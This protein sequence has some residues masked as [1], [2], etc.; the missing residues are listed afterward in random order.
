MKRG[1]LAATSGCNAETIRYYEKIGLIPEPRRAANGYREYD[2]LHQERLHFVQRGRE[3]GFTIDD[4]KSLLSLVDRN[5]VSCNEVEKMA[6]Q[7]L[8]S[9]QNKIEQLKRMEVIL[10]E[11]INSCSGEDVP[12]CPLI[13]SLFN[14]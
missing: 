9:V 14:D 1:E 6:T 2:K 4:L 7:H 5:A 12:E 8:E 10:A 13:E 11:T 3:L